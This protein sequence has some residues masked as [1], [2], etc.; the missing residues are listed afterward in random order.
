MKI[1]VAGTV[2]FITITASGLYSMTSLMTAST[3]DVSK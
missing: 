1:A 2:D 3:D